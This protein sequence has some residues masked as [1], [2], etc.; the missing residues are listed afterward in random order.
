MCDLDWQTAVCDLAPEVW[1]HACPI[2]GAS[3]VESSGDTFVVVDTL[4]Q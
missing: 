2:R 3:R 4:A 1:E